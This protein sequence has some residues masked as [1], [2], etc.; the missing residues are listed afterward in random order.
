VAVGGSG[1]EQAVA[2]FQFPSPAG[3]EEMFHAFEAYLGEQLCMIRR[4][5]RSTLSIIFPVV[6]CWKSAA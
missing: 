5:S 6:S 3:F 1:F 4:C 2:A